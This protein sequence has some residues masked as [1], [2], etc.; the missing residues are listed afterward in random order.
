[1]RSSISLPAVPAARFR[2]RARVLSA[3]VEFVRVVCIL[4]PYRRFAKN[5]SR[6]PHFDYEALYQRGEHDFCD[7]DEKTHTEYED[8]EEEGSGEQQNERKM[9]AA[10]ILIA[11]AVVLPRTNPKMAPNVEPVIPHVVT[12]EITSSDA[13]FAV[14]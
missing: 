9:T 13:V 14:R 2:D 3:G 7:S 4:N 12:A 6:A 5:S 10:T 11:R 8:R 1:M